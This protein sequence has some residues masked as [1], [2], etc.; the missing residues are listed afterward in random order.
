MISKQYISAKK[1]KIKFNFIE[2]IIRILLNDI[3][4]KNN[5][6]NVFLWNIFISLLKIDI[7]YL[8]TF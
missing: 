5:K 8:F 1:K 3:I 4:D 2:N 6:K 7:F